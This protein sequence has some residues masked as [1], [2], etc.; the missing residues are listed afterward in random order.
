MPRKRSNFKKPK[1]KETQGEEEKRLERLEKDR[2]RK[3]IQRANKNE[4]KRLER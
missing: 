4:E 1:G 2:L 3:R